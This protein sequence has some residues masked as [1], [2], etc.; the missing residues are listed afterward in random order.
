MLGENFLLRGCWGAGTYCPEKVVPS[1]PSRSLCEA[2]P[3]PVLE[4]GWYH[5]K[6]M[7]THLKVRSWNYYDRRKCRAARNKTS[8]MQLLIEELNSLWSKQNI[9]L[10][11]WWWFIVR[12]PLQWNAILPAFLQLSTPKSDLRFCWIL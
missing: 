9:K 5:R 3:A 10:K 4:D 12:Y 6:G 1:N 11:L 8:C 2:A 7:E